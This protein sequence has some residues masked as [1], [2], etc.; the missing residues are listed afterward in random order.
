MEIQT[1]ID[2]RRFITEVLQVIM[3]QQGG[4]FSGSESGLLSNTH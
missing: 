1:D 2:M 3:L 4:S